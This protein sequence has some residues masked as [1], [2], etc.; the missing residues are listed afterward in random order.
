MTNA[1]CPDQK[2][3]LAQVTG[4]MSPIFP[5]AFADPVFTRYQ[6][7]QLLEVRTLLQAHGW[8]ELYWHA[9][10]SAAFVLYPESHLNLVSHRVPLLY[11]SKARSL[12]LIAGSSS[13]PGS[14]KRALSRSANS[15]KG[16]TIGYGR[17]IPH[18]RTC[19]G[20]DY[21]PLATATALC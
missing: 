13:P 14:V 10:N 18:K 2:N 12:R 17:R 9:A 16:E 6:L 21:P 8:H 11:G 1:G 4:G 19:Q 15:P 3:P 20:R 5:A 7:S